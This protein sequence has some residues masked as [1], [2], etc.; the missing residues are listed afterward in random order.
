MDLI[1]T[2][3][4]IVASYYIFYKFIKPNFLIE[5]GPT[6]PKIKRNAKKTDEE[7][8]DYEEVEE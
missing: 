3:V 1:Y 5:Q 6:I 4:A 7:Y 8:V 2:I